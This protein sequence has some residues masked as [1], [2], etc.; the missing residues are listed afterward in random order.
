MKYAVDNFSDDE[1]MKIIRKFV[2]HIYG[3]QLTMKENSSGYISFYSS[4]PVPPYH[5][6]LSGRLWCNDDRLYNI[7]E[8]FFSIDGHQALALIGFYFSTYYG[9]KVTDTRFQTHIFFDVGIDYSQFDDENYKDED[10][11]IITESQ[12]DRYK[13]LLREY[14]KSMKYPG[15]CKIELMEDKEDKLYI[16]I[17]FSAEW[18]AE[19]ANTGGEM[20]IVK[21]VVGTLVDIKEVLEDTF[22]PMKFYMRHSIKANKDC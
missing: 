2:I 14:V 20:S 6:N 7:I 15:V 12:F 16:H 5:R 4:G 13:K 17:F 9:I 1:L 19:T 3:K 22:S 8:T 18:Y 10:E 11:D 21:K